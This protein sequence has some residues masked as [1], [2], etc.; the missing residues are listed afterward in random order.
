MTMSAPS[1]I[2]S[3]RTFDPFDEGRNVGGIVL[4]VGVDLHGGPIAV[5]H[6]VDETRAHGAADPEIDLQIEHVRPRFPRGGGR[7]V[8]GP[9]AH[10]EDVGPGNVFA[11]GLDD[12]ADRFFLVPR[13]N[14]DEQVV[15]R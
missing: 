2:S 12:A 10:N 6:R 15:W 3:R 14:D 1:S 8:A 13:G 7:P 9:V 5:V 4:P 11:D